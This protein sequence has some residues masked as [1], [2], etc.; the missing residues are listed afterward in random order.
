MFEGSNKW[1]AAT[2]VLC[3]ELPRAAYLVYGL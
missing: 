3:E 1:I 2:D